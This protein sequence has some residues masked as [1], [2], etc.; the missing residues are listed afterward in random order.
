ML[1]GWVMQTGLAS[2]VTAT[3]SDLPTSVPPLQSYGGPGGGVFYNGSD[4]AGGYTSAGFFFENSFNT[5]FSSWSGWA[6][7]TTTDTTTSGFTNQ[8][9]AYSGGGY[10]DS[11]YAVGYA[12][13]PIV[14]DLP[15]GVDQPVSVRLTNVTYPALSMENGDAF[16]KQFGGP[17]GDDP[18]FLLLTIEG[19]DATDSSLGTVDFY[20]AD[21]RFADNSLDTLVDS[22]Q[23]VDLSTLGDGVASLSFSLTGS[24]VGMFG[25]NTPAYF[26][27]DALSA[28]PE[29]AHLSLVVGLGL[30]FVLGWR[31]YRAGQ[32]GPG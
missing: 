4:L 23:L 28:I 29:P 24:D 7:S 3:F 14:I 31:R 11:I 21:Y 6:Y 18:D 9:S 2:G 15:T 1:V 27:L 25:L 17:S 22:W 10:G 19:L 26:A 16:A 13:S 12:P 20:L 8:Y 5:D 30:I 32:D